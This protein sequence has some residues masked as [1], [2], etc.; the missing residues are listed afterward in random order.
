MKL[1]INTGEV[2]SLDEAIKFTNSFQEQNPL[3]PKSF[4]VGAEKIKAILQ[5]D[6]CIGVRIYNGYDMDTAHVNLVLVGVN[7]DGED[8]TDGVIVERLSPCP[9]DCP[10]DSPLIKR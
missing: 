10:K 3:Q 8:I 9:P 5:Q 7:K 4:S 1:D 2:I 6:N